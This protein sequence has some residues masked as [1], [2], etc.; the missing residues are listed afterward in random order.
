MRLPAL[1]LSGVVLAAGPLGSAAQSLT[2]SITISPNPPTCSISGTDLDLGSYT[3]PLNGTGS[4]RMIASSNTLDSPLNLT[5]VS[6]GSAGGA[7]V[8]TEHTS[9]ATVTISYPSALGSGG[10]SFSG[11]W[12]QSS[13]GINYTDVS[14]DSHTFTGSGEGQTDAHYYLIG[15]TA[16]NIS[17]S[18]DGTY[19]G[20][21]TVSVTCT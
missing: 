10:P 18:M 20:T 6:G 14:G 4:V 17:N 9:S 8:S 12:A 3:R 7:T 16:S 15:G 5:Y 21:I 1:I 13:S 11:E 2:A 19:S